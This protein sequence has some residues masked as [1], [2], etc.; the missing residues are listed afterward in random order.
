MTTP[1]ASSKPDAPVVKCPTCGAPSLFAPSNRFRP[2]CSER[3]QMIDLGAWGNE[4]F[5]VPAATP[6]QDE[7]YGDPRHE[8]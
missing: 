3:C 8:D 7:T 6:P 4:E 2:F 1:A 5:R